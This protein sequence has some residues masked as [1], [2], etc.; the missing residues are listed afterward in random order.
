MIK[1]QLQRGVVEI[2]SYIYQPTIAFRGHVWSSVFG[3]YTCKNI[4]MGEILH[5]HTWIGIT[6]TE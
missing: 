3:H 1:D 4:K 5:T 6:V 2:E